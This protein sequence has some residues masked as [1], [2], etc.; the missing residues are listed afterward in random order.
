MLW[1]TNV[2]SARDTYF[3]ALGDAATDFDDT[4]TG[5]IDSYYNT[6]L[7]A[8]ITRSQSHF[9]ALHTRYDALERA[10]NDYSVASFNAAKDAS[11][12]YLDAGNYS[13]EFLIA[14]VSEGNFFVLRK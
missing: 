2:K 8:Q 14:C 1:A 4:L 7:N 3:T 10:M 9:D 13:A 5:A 11:L 12:N 6:M